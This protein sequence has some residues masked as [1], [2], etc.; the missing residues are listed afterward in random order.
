MIKSQG[1]KKRKRI[2]SS[3]SSENGDSAVSVSTRIT[4]RGNLS[5][6]V[7]SDNT[8][9]ST[10]SSSDETEIDLAQMTSSQKVDFIINKSSALE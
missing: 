10:M 5:R 9:N 6:L 1:K 7:E 8:E 2:P 4:Q 3:T